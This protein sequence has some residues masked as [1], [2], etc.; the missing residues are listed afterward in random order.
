MIKYCFSAPPEIS[1]AYGITTAYHEGDT[2][3]TLSFKYYPPNGYKYYTKC[4]YLPQQGTKEDQ[5]MFHQEGN[6]QYFGP[7]KNRARVDTSQAGTF[8]LTLTA[9]TQKDQGQYRCVFNT[10]RS[11][12]R[13]A[14]VKLSKK[15]GK[16]Y[17][18]MSKHKCVKTQRANEQD[19]LSLPPELADIPPPEFCMSSL[20]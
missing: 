17:F 18:S 8:N 15:K 3:S 6:L 2:S 16:G 4:Y 7:L 20:T 14:V 11:I 9:P 5:V 10:N 19:R 13:S 1:Y 12:D